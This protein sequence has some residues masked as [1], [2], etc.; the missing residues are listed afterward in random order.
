V[1]K[2]PTFRIGGGLHGRCSWSSRSC[3]IANIFFLEDHCIF[4][5]RDEERLAGSRN[6]SKRSGTRQRLVCCASSRFV[7]AIH[8]WIA[9]GKSPHSNEPLHS[10][11]HP[12]RSN[13]ILEAESFSRMVRQE[14]CVIL[15][16]APDHAA[17][18]RWSLRRC[19]GRDRPCR[20][21]KCQTSSC[22][23]RRSQGLRPRPHHL[24]HRKYQ[25]PRLCSAGRSN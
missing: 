23:C 24:C 15:S 12:R 25:A 1:D 22:R 3:P 16:V 14:A 2:T 8:E 9:P 21:S 13:G 19:F 7:G 11:G 18:V 6:G 4:R 10:N 20:R 5:Y 17:T